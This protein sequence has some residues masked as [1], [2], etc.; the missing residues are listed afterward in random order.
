[1]AGLVIAPDYM[2]GVVEEGYVLAL[3]SRMSSAASYLSLVLIRSG[4]YIGRRRVL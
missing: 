4:V 1:M 3:C 2:A